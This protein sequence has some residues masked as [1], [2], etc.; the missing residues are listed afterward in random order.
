MQ[1]ML[2]NLLCHLWYCSSTTLFLIGVF[3]HIKQQGSRP[4]HILAQYAKGISSYE[5]WI[6]DY[7]CMIEVA[8]AHNVIHFA[9]AR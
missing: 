8:P 9:S 1:L 3:S 6:E 7:P 5:T 4:A 2:S